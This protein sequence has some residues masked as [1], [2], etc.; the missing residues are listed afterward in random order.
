MNVLLSVSI[1]V[2]VVQG[3]AVLTTPKSRNFLASPAG[4]NNAWPW[5]TCPQC[6]SAGGTGSV[7]KAQFELTGSSRWPGYPENVEVAKRHAACGSEKYSDGGEFS[8][9][10]E[11]YSGGAN[12]GAWGHEP[13]AQGSVISLDVEMH[14]H[15]QGHFE[16]Y[17]CDKAGQ[18]YGA[19]TDAAC[20]NQ[21]RLQRAPDLD[22]EISPTD[23]NHP[24]R[25]YVPP[26][27]ALSA[28]GPNRRPMI[29]NM[30]YMLPDD[31]A[32][33]HCVL[34]SVYVTGN[35]CNPND[36][37]EYN[38]P[39][40]SETCPSAHAFERWWSPTIV[41]CFEG[42]YPEEF[43][44]CAD[45]RIA[46]GA[47]G[48]NNS[49]SATNSPATMPSYS[50]TTSD[51]AAI[52]NGDGSLVVVGLTT[53]YFQED[54]GTNHPV[55]FRFYNQF[56]V[57]M[58][59]VELGAIP[60]SGSEFEKEFV[61]ASGGGA[62][63]EVSEG[64]E[65]AYGELCVGKDGSAEPVDDDAL[66]ISR[67]DTYAWVGG[68]EFISSSCNTAHVKELRVEPGEC[69]RF[70]MLPVVYDA[71]PSPATTPLSPPSPPTSSRPTPPPTNTT[72]PPPPAASPAPNCGGEPCAVSS[73]CRSK[74]GACGTGPAWC[75]DASTW[76]GSC[77]SA[78][79]LA[80]SEEPPPPPASR[81]TTAPPPPANCVGDPCADRTHCRSQ[82]GFCGTGPSW[83]NGASTWVGSCGSASVAR[84][85]EATVLASVG[86]TNVVG[87][88][89]VK[90]ITPEQ[91]NKDE[92]VR[93]SLA[94]D[95]AYSAGVAPEDVTI[96]RVHELAEQDMEGTS[97]PTRKRRLQ[98]ADVLLLLVDYQIAFESDA[99]AQVGAGRLHA[100]ESFSNV[101]VY[102]AENGYSNMHVNIVAST[103]EVVNIGIETRESRKEPT[104]EDGG[105]VG[106]MEIVV[107]ACAAAAAVVALAGGYVAF[108]KRRGVTKQKQAGSSG[109]VELQNME[110]A[111]RSFSTDVLKF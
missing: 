96:V 81:P 48:G 108:R 28:F 36:Y 76:V 45:I 12:K 105:G 97:G 11:K 6:A 14:A 80:P 7:Q 52:E 17:I 21:H 35:S 74:W 71:E 61:L 89:A 94:A 43:W 100:L 53:E 82:W 66:V 27:C 40:I 1:F 111:H 92:S 46:A 84:S 103:V 47:N 38:W 51:P 86:E 23:P 75:N 9:L 95:L 39:D 88:V 83:C 31:L 19:E 91:F 42:S 78:P 29:Q 101:E 25:Y 33:E 62:A 58:F 37:A 69:Q 93:E 34:Q 15:H 99:E 18:T 24:E 70:L 8:P 77:A 5:D 98:N 49:D 63:L 56:A 65:V 90:G 50:P 10:S 26:L 59:S 68:V 67:G 54:A 73:H 4:G 16:F 60:K 44:N 104:E 64:L 72:P 20:L 106:G 30:R 110:A 85:S 22:N 79:P 55:T 107:G 57:W 32:C 3:H 87:Q 109:S 102:A 2:V 41:D 13:Y